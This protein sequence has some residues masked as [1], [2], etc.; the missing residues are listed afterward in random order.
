VGI[1]RWTGHHGGEDDLRAP[2]ALD[3]LAV[4]AFGD[5]DFDRR[6]G[7]NLRSDE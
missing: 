2:D 6:C 1:G 7:R 5:D 4:N 3:H